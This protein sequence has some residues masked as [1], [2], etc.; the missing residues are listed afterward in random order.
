MKNLIFGF[1]ILIAFVSCAKNKISF[2]QTQSKE[3]TISDSVI[4]K[5]ETKLPLD[6][7][8]K[9]LISLQKTTDKTLKWVAPLYNGLQL[10]KATQN[11]V[12]KVFGEPKEQFHPFSEYES[13]KDKWIFYYENINNF[14][15]SISFTFD[16]RSKILNEVWLR[17]NYEKPLMIEKAIEIYGKDYFLRGVSKNICS[18]KKLTKIEYPFTIVYPQKGIFLWV[19]EGEEVTDIFYITK[20]P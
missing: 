7:S 15:G 5:S 6:S 12:I 19:R 13:T 20:C 1:L 10:G 11:D 16:I 8:F 9:N 14:G 17:P 2:A 18:S 4:E 3:N